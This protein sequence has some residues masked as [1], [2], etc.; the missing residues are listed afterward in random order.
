M[1]Q[2]QK[3]TLILIA[4]TYGLF[5]SSCTSSAKKD[6]VP[7]A[8]VTLSARWVRDSLAKKNDGFR[9]IN[10]MTP[11]VYKNKIIMG[12]A[13]DGLVAYNQESGQELWRV[14]IP[15]GVEASGTAIRDRLFVGSNNGKM[16]S[17]DL[18][19][20][21]VL[22]TFDTKSEAVAE[23]LLFDGSLY[24]I[25]GSQSIFALDA[26]TGKQLW[27]YNRQDTSNL[28]TIRGG[29][30][31]ALSNGIL[32]VG[33]SDG[34]L[35][36]FNAKTGSQ[37]W[38]ISLNKN[39]RFKDIDS[40]PIVDGD[41]LYINSYDDKL[42][43]VSK[44]KGEIVWSVKSGGVSTPV[45]SGDRIIF[46][47]SKSEMISVY[48]KDGKEFWRF[49]SDKG[50][51]T[52]PV[53]FKGFVV[54][55][56]SQGSLILLDLLTGAKKASFDPGRGVFSRPTVQADQNNIYFI[57]GEGNAYSIR[58]SINAPEEPSFLR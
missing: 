55:G 10:R 32:Y 57:S 16:Y 18:T 25:S 19:N 35:V 4:M 11:I 23:P 53:L 52:D 8:R 50:I 28:M 42:Y 33:F 40:S 51:M 22:W 24:F 29:S 30:K 43:C 38:E 3:I 6:S 13:V 15:Y 21:S 1:T 44:N 56:E 14:N 36:S 17:I 5:F 39:T 9:K 54:A 45:I 7:E 37:Q 46:G 48:K 26:A 12:N 20:G 47:S 34:S 58:A 27:T 2:L 49:K 41:Y 31:P